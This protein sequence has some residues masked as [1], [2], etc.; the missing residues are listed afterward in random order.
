MGATPPTAR[1]ET[2]AVGSVPW[3]LAQTLLGVAITLVPWVA[4]QLSS[5]ATSAGGSP[6]KPLSP[7]ADL[8]GGIFALIFSAIV[9]GAFLLVPA[10]YTYARRAPGTTVHD[11]LRALG[12]RRT[13]LR[14]A[15]QAA[16]I[17]LGVIIGVNIL[18]SA[19]ISGLNSTVHWHIQTNSDSL[20][21]LAHTMPLTLMGYLVAAV[22]VAPVCEEIF[23]RGFAFGGLLHGMS[24]WPAAGV[25]AAL[26]GIA[27]VDAGSFPVLF[28]IGVVLAYMRW[29]FGSLLPGMAL[30]AC[31]NALAALLIVG[32]LLH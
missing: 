15:A 3:T 29:R 21:H 2:G 16:G 4:V 8:L 32:V 25:S 31:N 10:Y 14:P 27:H 26:F 28:V 17:G 24:L 7:M 1:V 5:K 12:L 6:T 20:M 23:F 19:L 22:L 30:H 9:E 13:E 18:Y 11:D